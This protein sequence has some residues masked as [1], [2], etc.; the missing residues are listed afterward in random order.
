MIAKD[1][2][3][4]I[5]TIKN[6]SI[7]DRIETPIHYRPSQFGL[8]DKYTGKG[9]KIAI[10]DTGE[11]KHKDIKNGQMSVSFCES[12]KNT[13]DKIGHAT[14]VSGIIVS[15]N[16]NSIIGLAPNS[17]IYYGK[18]MSDNKK[19]SFNS[20]VAGVLWSIVKEVDIIVL[21]LGCQYDYR[22]L[23][24]A[25]IKARNSGICIFAAAG[26]DSENIDFPADYKEV[27]SCGFLGRNK[28]INTSIKSKVDFYCPNRYLYSTYINDQYVKIGG[29][30]I[31]T[32]FFAGL[33]ATLI[34]HYKDQVKK[35]E[36]P[37]F[38]YQNLL[39][40]LK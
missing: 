39:K 1:T 37:D 32:S 36:R 5:E 20:L 28:N 9:V 35:E 26:E 19:V 18:I 40:I 10:L 15:N 16:K 25:L 30:S 34:E 23:H 29:S 31:A 27:F 4:N 24:D 12:N 2:N 38:I 8:D 3:I 14:L 33:G 22:I 13:V 21:A 11:P 17:D 6:S 7:I